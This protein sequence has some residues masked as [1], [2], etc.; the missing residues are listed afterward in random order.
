MSDNNKNDGNEED[1]ATVLFSQ[2]NMLNKLNAVEKEASSKPAALM[3][4][5]GELN[6]TLFDLAKNETTV[7]RNPDNTIP[8]EFNGISRYHFK[9]VQQG[10]GH[11]LVDNQSKNGTFLNNNKLEQDQLLKKGDIIK[12]GSLCLKYLPKGDPERLTYD[13]L[14]LD[15]NTD[16]HTGCF[17]KIYF[18]NMLELQVKKSRLQ[19]FP[20]SLII[21]DLDHFKN[22]NDTYGHN[23]GD[24]VLKELAELIRQNGTRKNQDVFARYGGEEFCLLLPE[25]NIKQAFEIAERL[26]QLVEDNKFTYDNKEL[27]VTASLGVADYREGVFNGEDLFRRADKAVYQSKEEGRNRVTY[28]RN[29]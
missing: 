29:E 7:G 6:G 16:R 27:P 2:N 25:T 9:I 18:N 15:A 4:V 11:Q 17:N 8:L 19:G 24:F 14:N 1:N 13:K 3:V 20:L 22:L 26:R 12:I 23:A 21:F 5:G 28:Y 10:D